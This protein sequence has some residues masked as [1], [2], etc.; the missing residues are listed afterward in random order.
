MDLSDSY[1]F[2]GRTLFLSAWYASVAP[3]GVVFSLLGILMNYWVDKIQL[4]RYQSIPP[5]LTD[6]IFTKV[7]NVLEILPLV[8]M[9]G[10]IE[11]QIRI[12]VS[13]NLFMFIFEF[14]GYGAT[15]ISLFFMVLAYLIFFR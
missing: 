4:L 7:L 2:I 8:Y 9:C 1:V 11:Y 13:N 12:T 6:Q 3:L 14:F 10:S 15:S 5:Q